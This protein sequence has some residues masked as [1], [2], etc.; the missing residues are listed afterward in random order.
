VILTLKISF[1]NI[2]FFFWLEMKFA[3]GV[4]SRDENDEIISNIRIRIMRLSLLGICIHDYAIINAVI[5]HCP[6]MK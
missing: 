6:N 1:F 4:S 2:F 3:Y 5:I